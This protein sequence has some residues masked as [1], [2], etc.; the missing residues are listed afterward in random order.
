[1]KTNYVFQDKDAL[2]QGLTLAHKYNLFI[3]DLVEHPEAQVYRNGL[4]YI[5]KIEIDQKAFL[6]KRLVK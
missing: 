5:T 3:D 4:G 1:M 2:Q 6:K